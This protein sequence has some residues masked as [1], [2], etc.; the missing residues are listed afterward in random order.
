FTLD[1]GAGLTT[2]SK[3]LI[4]N[5]GMPL[6]ADDKVKAVGAGGSVPVMRSKVDHF[7][8]GS[9]AL[10]NEKVMVIDFESIFGSRWASSGLI[11][12]SFLKNYR[13]TINYKDS[14][15]ELQQNL[16]SEV[17]EMIDWVPFRYLENTHII[18]VPVYINN[19]GPY[20]FILDTGSSGTILSPNLVSKLG[21]KR[22]LTEIE[23]NV[24]EASGCSNGE[25]L[26]VGGVTK[27]YPLKLDQLSIKS[28]IQEKITVDVID[29]KVVAPKCPKLDHGV[30]GYPFL[31]D[32]IVILDYPNKRVG[33]IKQKEHN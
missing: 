2:V 5:L 3:N 4:T 10:E 11:G 8:I 6:I 18:T 27:G 25:C 32:F 19:E 23:K 7:R 29:L 21:L 22:N 12:Q 16:R 9:E 15:L 1:T 33:F 20:D 24:K 13:V 28:A 17:D 31:K 14:N 30:I 26:G